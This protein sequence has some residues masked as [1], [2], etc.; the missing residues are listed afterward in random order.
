MKVYTTNK[1]RFV[2]SSGGKMVV[3]QP[4]LPSSNKQYFEYPEVSTT[5][6]VYYDHMERQRVYDNAG[7]PCGEYA[8]LNTGESYVVKKGCKLTTASGCNSRTLTVLP[9]HTIHCEGGVYYIE[10]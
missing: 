10:K 4:S 7:V 2:K 1:E 6:V 3:H 9:G 5:L 8:L